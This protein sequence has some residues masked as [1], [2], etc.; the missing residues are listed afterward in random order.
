MC[1]QVCFT[2]GGLL[3]SS[4]CECCKLAVGSFKQQV[5]FSYILQLIICV[6]IIFLIAWITPFLQLFEVFGIECP[7]DQGLSCLGVSIIYRMSFAL[8]VCHALIFLALLCKNDFSRIINEQCW[9]SKVLLLIGSFV[10]SMFIENSFF[11]AYSTLAKAFSIVF[12]LFQIVMIIDICY[13]W[14]E[15]W[16]GNYDQGQN[17]YAYLLI[18]L[19]VVLY[20]GTIVFN[21]MLYK[22]F[23]GCGAGSLAIT[24]NIVLIVIATI[25]PLTKINPN[26][27]I[28]TSSTVSAYTTY[29]TYAGLSNIADN[30]NPVRFSSSGAI[31]FLVTGSLLV[32]ISLLYV[33]FGDSQ[34]SSG[35]VQVA[36]NTDIAKGVLEDS[37]ENEREYEEDKEDMENSARRNENRQR[38]NN[39]SHNQ[40]YTN[41]RQED[42]IRGK[43]SDYTRSNGYIYF[44]LIM[45]ATGFYMSM[46]LTNW[47]SAAVNGRTFSF[48]AKN[49]ESEWFMISTSWFTNLLYIWTIIAPYFCASREF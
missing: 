19:T 4:V 45:I 7:K 25:L 36:S 11:T 37:K 31:L 32:L 23:S 17:C 33:T 8:V 28:F 20:V 30:C 5:R 12:L 47:G 13:L 40:D 10:G 49:D 43:L 16:V 6:A 41:I 3:C 15:R 24:T 35:N 22:W 42:Q 34:T 14:N 18:C 9:A 48:D 39:S 1:L 29:L 38:P 26:G 46:L 21:V 27:S 44:H 2:T